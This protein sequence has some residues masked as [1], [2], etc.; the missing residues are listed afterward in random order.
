M[1]HKIETQLEQDLELFSSMKEIG[2]PDYFYTRLMVRMENDASA[3]KNSFI[4]KPVL[5]ISALTIFLLLNSLFLNN[6][7]NLNNIDASQNIEAF[8]AAYDQTITN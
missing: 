1:K 7:A 8:A 5:I 4:L 6:D 3:I 2:A